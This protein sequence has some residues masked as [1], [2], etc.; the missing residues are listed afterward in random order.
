MSGGLIRKPIGGTSLGHTETPDLNRSS[1]VINS[2]G[3]ENFLN[4][5]PA[6]VKAQN[7]HTLFIKSG[8]KDV[9]TETTSGPLS[10]EVDSV[11]K[12]KAFTSINPN[13]K[14]SMCKCLYSRMDLD[15]YSLLVGQKQYPELTKFDEQW[16]SD[17][18]GRRNLSKVFRD[19]FTGNDSN[20][21]NKHAE[22]EAKL[23]GGS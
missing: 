21:F 18:A 5:A 7:E 3:L 19:L 11:S 23:R 16:G 20:L 14:D 9:S 12:G 6:S 1:N 4:M 15:L 10:V 17:V 8:Q 22:Y 2:D 13:S